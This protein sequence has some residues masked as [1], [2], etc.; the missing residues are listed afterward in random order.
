MYIPEHQQNRFAMSAVINYCMQEY[1]TFDNKSKR[2]LISGVNCD[3]ANAFQEFMATK[4]VYGKANGVFFYQYVQS[5][6]PT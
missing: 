4:K 5:F 1:K 6:S 2:Q 3:G